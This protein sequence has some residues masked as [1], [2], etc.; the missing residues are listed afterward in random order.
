M[1]L[2][3]QNNQITAITDSLE[4]ISNQ[5]S[6]SDSQR[7]NNSS[8]QVS[9]YYI[10]LMKDDQDVQRIRKA[11]IPFSEVLIEHHIDLDCKHLTL[12]H[13]D[14]L[15]QLTYKLECLN[16]GVELQ[17]TMS[18]YE[19]IQ[20]M[21]DRHKDSIQEESIDSSKHNYFYQFQSFLK[22]IFQHLN[23]WMNAIQN[24]RDK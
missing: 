11:L 18:H 10:P 19:P 22:T 21:I 23:Q 8:M 7:S 16:L 24:K 3:Q 6:F 4:K 15:S 1:A 17:Q 13:R 20:I 14:D 9:Y 5:S 2:E 12:Y